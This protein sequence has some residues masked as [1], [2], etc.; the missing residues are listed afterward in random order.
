MRFTP[1]ISDLN[2]EL[3]NAYVAVKDNVEKII[4]FLTQHGI[5]YNQ[6]PEEYY[7]KLRSCYNQ[8]GCSDRIERAAMFIA[9][10]KTCYNG[11]YRV[12][13]KGEFNVPWGKYKNL[14]ICDSSNLRNVSHILSNCKVTIKAADY[15]EML[16]KN[17][18]E[19]DFI[20]LDPP[21]SPWKFN[22]IFY[23]LYL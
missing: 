3:I 7:Y 16:L 4:D 11:L 20:Y 15:K 14:T 12:N 23:K 5:G 10:N 9:L 17:A 6:A 19:N 22:S 2:S 8:R 13:R 1:Y 21:Y 18:K